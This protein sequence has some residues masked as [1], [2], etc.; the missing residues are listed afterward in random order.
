MIVYLKRIL[1]AVAKLPKVNISFMSVICLSVPAR[2][3]SIW[4]NYAATE[5]VFSTFYIWVFFEIKG[6]LRED[7]VR[8][9]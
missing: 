6:T 2:R 7:Y 1:D 5:R 8:W 3:P 4:S 9:W